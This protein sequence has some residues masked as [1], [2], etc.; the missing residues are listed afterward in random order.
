MLKTLFAKLFGTFVVLGLL[1]SCTMTLVLQRS[2]ELVWLLIGD[3]V[4]MLLAAGAAMLLIARPAKHLRRAM[5]S[6][7]ASGFKSVAP[8]QRRLPAMPDELDRLAER[9]VSIAGQVASR[10][11]SLQCSDDV[12][13]QLLADIA[14]DLKTPLTAMQGYVDT[15]VGRNSA[16]SEGDRRRYLLMLQWHARKMSAFVESILELARLEAPEMRL[17]AEWFSLDELVHDIVAD[18]RLQT[19]TKGLAFELRTSAGAGIEADVALVERAIRNVLENAVRVSP[20]GGVVEIQIYVGATGDARVDISDSGPGIASGEAERIFSRFYSRA[21]NEEPP[22]LGLGLAITRRIVEL[23]GG[24]VTCANRSKGG[25]W[26]GLVLPRRPK[27]S[28][29]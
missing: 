23:H 4:L 2:H 17:R 9:F 12:R 20:P 16:L 1:V 3:L 6:F 18:L 5:E 24:S 21:W 22:G 13:K 26:F 29:G 10:I 28:H 14:H 11:A 15:V 8:Y 19:D 27:S 7:E 25:A